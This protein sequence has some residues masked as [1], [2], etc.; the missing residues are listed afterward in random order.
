MK[1]LDE[2]NDES[3]LTSKKPDK[4]KS[5]ATIPDNST[6]A[7]N[8]ATEEIDK[9][10]DESKPTSNGPDKKISKATTPNNS[11]ETNNAGAR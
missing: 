3:K 9:P 4:E 10:E 11:I 7:T 6:E 2:H 5:K 8:A 1:K